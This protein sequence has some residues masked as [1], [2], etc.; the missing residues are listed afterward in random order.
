[1]CRNFTPTELEHF[2][3]SAFYKQIFPVRKCLIL[4]LYNLAPPFLWPGYFGMAIFFGT[5]IPSLLLILSGLVTSGG[6][7][8]FLC[9]CFGSKH[10]PVSV[11][12]E[13]RLSLGKCSTS[14]C[15]LGFLFS[16]CFHS[17]LGMPDGLLA[18]CFHRI[19]H[20]IIYLS[21]ILAF[22]L[23]AAASAAG[24]AAIRGSIF[25]SAAPTAA[26]SCPTPVSTASATGRTIASMQLLQDS[27]L[28]IMPLLLA[29]LAQFL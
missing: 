1:M 27:S 22:R 17:D 16:S 15:L 4:M 11:I 9:N 3:I 10:S 28:E 20:L 7:A 23:V 14:P 26:I 25:G 29:S 5:N 2:S 21:R 18:F 8:I 13:Q 24:S 19:A 12:L 6:I